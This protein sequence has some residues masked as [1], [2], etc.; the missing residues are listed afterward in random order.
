MRDLISMLL[1]L[2][3]LLSQC[4]SSGG[5]DPIM[6][7]GDSAAAPPA[8]SS[9]PE[10]SLSFADM[11]E[12][13]CLSSGAGGWST[14]LTLD[15][16]GYF[17]GSYYDSDMGDTGEGYPGGT[18][19]YCDFEGWFSQPERIDEYTWS[20]WVEELYY[21][22]PGEPYIEDDIRWV[23][24]TPYGLE[25]VKDILIYL[26]GSRV[27]DLPEEFMFWDYND[28]DSE[29]LSCWGLYNVDEQLGFIGYDW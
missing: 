10:E 25:Y 13:F 27:A 3:M 4:G 19:Y 2:L 1:I 28:Y 9:Q 20:T 21:D 29:E 6:G 15:A 22:E 12:S 16:E 11:P 26:P 23:P 24:S 8:P 18:V 14:D 7:G 5:S 17:Y